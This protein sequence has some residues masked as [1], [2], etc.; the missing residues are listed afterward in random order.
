MSEPSL[1]SGDDLK[2]QARVL[3]EVRRLVDEWR[4]F[5][6]GPADEPYSDEP[7][8]YAPVRT[9]ER[10][11][12]DTTSILL[13]HWF[14]HE[15]HAVGPDRTTL[16]KYWPHQRRAVETFIY[17]YEVR[18]IRRSEDLWR[19]AG[20]DPIGDQND[21]W[22]KIGAQMATGSGK[23]KIMSLVIAWSYLNAL[24]APGTGS[25][26]GFGRH[27]LVVAPNLFVR[28]RL[29]MDFN[30]P[31]G[32]P[33]VFWS[34]PVVPPEFERDWDLR[35]YD[36]V[37]CPLTLEPNQGALV[38]TNFHQLLRTRENLDLPDETLARQMNLLFVEDR[39]SVV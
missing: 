3:A 31:H 12:T 29:F 32:S 8:R 36:P 30:P 10:S 21:P 19:L 20:A 9:G 35:V 24:H 7:P 16:F 13:R 4:G 37:T 14:R 25:G 2:G 23:T 22:A 6:L 15:P 33:S 11:L 38:V 34:D 28:D 1:F 18:G 17:L 5:P 27:A 26:L 39:K